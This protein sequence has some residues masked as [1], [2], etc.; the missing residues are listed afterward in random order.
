MSN[1]NE[2]PKYSY[3]LI[4]SQQG[5]STAIPDGQEGTGTGMQNVEPAYE[6]LLKINS[7]EKKIRL[8]NDEILGIKNNRDKYDL[9]IDNSNRLNEVISW[10]AFLVP[11][12]LI[13][14]IYLVFSDIISN[15]AII[16]QIVLGGVPTL[17]SA[18]FLV[19]VAFFLPERIK[20]MSQRI[21]QLE[22]K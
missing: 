7:L 18:I 20:L 3:R 16:W 2:L 8:I 10:L 21:D 1:N 5:S 19:R 6:N 15:L 9:L 4:I 17:I 22:K 12:G 14:V 11:V 13:L